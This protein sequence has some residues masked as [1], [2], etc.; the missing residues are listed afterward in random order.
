MT[1]DTLIDYVLNQ[2]DPSER[3][4]VEAHLA[5]RPDDLVRVARLRAALKPLDADRDAFDPPP[6]L[7]VAAVA[8]ADLPVPSSRRRAVAD[9]EPVFPGGG[10]RRF[11]LLVAAGIGFLAF[12]L[13]IAG[14]GKLRHEWQVMACQNQLRELY[15][16]LD[17][18]AGTHGGRYPEVGTEK[19]PT[20]GA[21]VVELNRAGQY[22]A[23]TAVCPVAVAEPID[24]P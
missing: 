11:D 10:W 14:V 16:A 13:V 1:D 12:G 18:Y 6:G 22:Q 2:L 7:A 15:A 20:A 8:P 19:V 24:D 4:E 5:A 23:V 3:A 21:F 9:L 17:G